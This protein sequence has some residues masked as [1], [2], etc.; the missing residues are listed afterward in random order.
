ME[1]LNELKEITNQII[2]DSE[3]LIQDLE[4]T[5]EID[6]EIRQELAELKIQHYKM[7]KIMLL[8]GSITALYSLMLVVKMIMIA[9]Q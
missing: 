2:S 7:N 6:E 4:E 1:E 8:M 9:I 5:L 3:E